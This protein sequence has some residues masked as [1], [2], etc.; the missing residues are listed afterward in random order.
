MVHGG[1]QDGE[2]KGEKDRHGPRPHSTWAAP[3]SAVVHSGPLHKSPF[4]ETGLLLG[5][6]KEETKRMKRKMSEKKRT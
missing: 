1:P 6:E 5:G 4:G 2:E 3:P